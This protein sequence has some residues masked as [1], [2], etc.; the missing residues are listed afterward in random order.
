[1]P[2]CKKTN[3]KERVGGKEGSKAERLCQM[4]KQL[5]NLLLD[6]YSHGHPFFTRLVEYM[7]LG[8]CTIGRAYYQAIVAYP[9]GTAEYGSHRHGAPPQNGSRVATQEYHLASKCGACHSRST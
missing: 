1:M 6:V 3:R 2:E 9:H 7:Q 5:T 8:D 4:R